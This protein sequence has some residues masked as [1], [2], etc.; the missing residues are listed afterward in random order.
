MATQASLDL[1][2]KLY[3]AYY[4]RPAD[5]AGQQYWAEQID[6]QGVDSVINFFGTSPEFDA[7]FGSMSN[8]QLVNNL[9]FQLFGRSA[10]PEGLAFYAGHL[11]AGNLT[12]AEIALTIATGAQNEDVAA[13]NNKLAVAQSFTNAI[14][15]PNEITAYQGND[16]ANSARQFLVNVDENTDASAVDVEGFL[17]QLVRASGD[18]STQN[19][20]TLTE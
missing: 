12:L 1:V 4:G 2:Q 20:F 16:A 5:P 19:V 17:A 3:V 10:E 14:D 6:E 13:L 18:P 7:R 9:Y 15:D 11:D 8:E